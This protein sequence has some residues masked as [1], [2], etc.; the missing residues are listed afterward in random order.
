MSSPQPAPVPAPDPSSAAPTVW[1]QSATFSGLIGVALGGLL[2]FGATWITTN[3]TISAE[4]G[5]QKAD[6]NEQRSEETRQKQAEIYD[7]VLKTGEDWA[8]SRAIEARCV[9]GS[10]V[11][12][13]RPH[14]AHGHNQ[15]FREAVWDV[16]IFGSGAATDAARSLADTIPG[17]WV[18]SDVFEIDLAAPFD[19]V[20]YS[21]A[22]ANFQKVMCSELPAQPKSNC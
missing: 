11:D 1:W 17:T 13:A 5:R 7:K 3:Q 16:Y 9:A 2:T 22:Y 6:F 20:A 8:L 15:A 18:G 4:N 14:D 21:D 12:C 10:E 19:D